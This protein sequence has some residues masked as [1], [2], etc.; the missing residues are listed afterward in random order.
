M[1]VVDQSDGTGV[2]VGV[3]VGLGLT[4]AVATGEGDCSAVATGVGEGMD[5]RRTML[6]FARVAAAVLVR[7]PAFVLAFVFGPVGV[8]PVELL[9][10]EPIGATLIPMAWLR[11]PICAPGFRCV[12]IF[13]TLGTVVPVR[14]IAVAPLCPATVPVVAA[15]LLLTLLPVRGVC[16]KVNGIVA[17]HITITP[18]LIDVIPFIWFS[19]HSSRPLFRLIFDF[20]K[21]PARAGSCY[22]AG[23][24]FFSGT[25]E[26]AGNPSFGI[27][28]VRRIE[29]CSAV[30]FGLVTGNY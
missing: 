2:G 12:P 1:S 28:L 3:G 9:F 24:G 29:L 8:V 26:V 15:V 17:T 14:G 25:S 4:E 6:S 21:Y 11:V 23:G 22:R 7:G 30:V 16:A 27:M 5:S 13:G 10:G 18:S 20:L 19:L